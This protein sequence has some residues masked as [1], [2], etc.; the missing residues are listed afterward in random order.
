MHLLAL[1]LFIAAPVPATAA[2]KDED[3]AKE[4]VT[5]FL[6]AVVAKDADALMKTVDVPF[7]IE[8]G[9]PSA[10]TI[11]KADELKEGLGKLV[12]GAD[13]DLVA[14]FKV[15]KVYDAAGI[16]KYAE[17]NKLPDLPKQAEKLVGKTGRM[18]MIVGKMGKEELV[19]V[20][21]KD[22]KALIASLPK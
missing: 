3:K 15:G 4:V 13:S 22:G 6:K 10:K 1:T 20:R 11:E 17:D 21:F 5:A 18:V 9:A 7:V 14:M 12:K 2:D 16:A 8:L 19:L